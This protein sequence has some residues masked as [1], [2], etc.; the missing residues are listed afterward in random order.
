MYN[1][2]YTYAF[3]FQFSYPYTE[4]RYFPILVWLPEEES[5]CIPLI[6]PGTVTEPV[7]SL[8]WCSCLSIIKTALIVE[9]SSASFI[10]AVLYHPWCSYLKLMKALPSPI[11]WQSPSAAGVCC[12]STLRKFPSRVSIE[13]LCFQETDSHLLLAVVSTL[14]SWISV[15]MV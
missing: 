1:A 6:N 2:K 15:T 5:I 14:R 8:S 7:G 4:L 9:Q 10:L 11:T 12:F 13:F 3:L